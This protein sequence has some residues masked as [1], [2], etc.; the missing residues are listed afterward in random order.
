MTEAATALER[1]VLPHLDALPTTVPLVV[2]A[3]H[4]FRENRS[5]RRGSPDR[6]AHGGLSLVESVAPV[7]V[8]EPTRD[9]SDAPWESG[10][11]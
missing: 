5:W 6:Y 7:A 9:E 11:A 2:L 4:G 3:D 8:L 10:P 1:H